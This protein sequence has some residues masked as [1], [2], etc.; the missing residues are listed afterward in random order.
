M[1]GLPRRFRGVIILNFSMRICILNSEQFHTR[2]R[3]NNWMNQARKY[4]TW[5]R[6]W[7][8]RKNVKASKRTYNTHLIAEKKQQSCNF[9]NKA[10]LKWS[11]SE[12]RVEDTHNS[13]CMRTHI[14]IIIPRM[15]NFVVHNSSCKTKKRL[16][17]KPTLLYIK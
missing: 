15:T 14:E 5:I 10:Q 12:K 9:K 2:Q 1:L 4:E 11:S 13:S 7:H 16:A 17:M 3:S 6:T 8:I